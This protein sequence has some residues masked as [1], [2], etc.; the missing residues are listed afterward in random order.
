MTNKLK[1]LIVEDDLS[2][3]DLYSLALPDERFEKHFSTD[4]I[5]AIEEYSAWHPD[6]ILLDIL[7]PNMPGHSVLKEIRKTFRDKSTTIIMSTS[8]DAKGDI[9]FCEKQGIQGYIIKPFDHKIL[10]DKVVEFHNS[11]HSG[12]LH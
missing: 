9:S 3:L 6:I 2:L 7:I 8:V 1:V 10:A 12:S 11:I 5:S 4:G